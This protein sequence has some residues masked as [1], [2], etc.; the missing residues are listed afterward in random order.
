MPHSSRRP[1]SPSQ[2]KLP[3]IAL[4]DESATGAAADA[5]AA[6]YNSDTATLDALLREVGPGAID[7]NSRHRLKLPLGRWG[8]DARSSTLLGA[9][10]TNVLNGAA[11]GACVRVLLEHGANGQLFEDDHDVAA[12]GNWAFH[13]FELATVESFLDAYDDED[14]DPAARVARVE[15]MGIAAARE[16]GVVVDLT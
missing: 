16:A 2:M 8:W 1:P 15:V 14:L 9:A 4:A 10:F 6:I 12:D 13:M 7:V 5:V 11:S 3:L